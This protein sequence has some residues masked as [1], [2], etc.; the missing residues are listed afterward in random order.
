MIDVND[1]HTH[2]L[3]MPTKVKATYSRNDD[4]SY[5]VFINARISESE[6]KE[7]YLHEVKHI[8]NEDQAEY[9]TADELESETHQD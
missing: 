3:N 6:Q 9:K 1:I 7:A 5:S 4:D 2:L 8:L